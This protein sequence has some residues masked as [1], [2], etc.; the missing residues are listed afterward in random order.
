MIIEMLLTMSPEL[1]ISMMPEDNA[2]L[3]VVAQNTASYILEREV[4]CL[5]VVD[6]A[7]LFERKLKSDL[8][9]MC[10]RAT[11]DFNTAIAEQGHPSV[12]AKIGWFT[13]NR[14]DCQLDLKEGYLVPSMYIH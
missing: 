6:N 13:I 5:N 10:V 1:M 7:L 12:V 3:A 2:K 8:D 11:T 9:S 14:F 4:S